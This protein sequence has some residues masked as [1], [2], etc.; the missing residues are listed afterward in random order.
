MKIM[1]GM[2]HYIFVTDLEK[3]RAKE[4]KLK[5]KKKETFCNAILPVLTTNP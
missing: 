2:S 1:D 4:T 3:S 5:M